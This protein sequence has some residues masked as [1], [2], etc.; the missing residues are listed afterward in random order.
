MTKQTQGAVGGLAWTPSDTATIQRPTRGIQVA[1]FG[2]VALGYPD[3]TTC[4][5]PACIEGV[6]HPH[7]GFT[8]VLETGTTAT[9]IVVAF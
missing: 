1:T 8:R 4:V 2:D 3:G 6:I 7:V 5:W 9:G